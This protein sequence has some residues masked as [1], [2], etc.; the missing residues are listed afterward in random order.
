MTSRRSWGARRTRILSFCEPSKCPKRRWVR[1]ARLDVPS[2]LLR[3]V[4]PRPPGSRRPPRRPTRSTSRST[5]RSSIVVR[6]DVEVARNALPDERGQPRGLEDRSNLRS[7]RPRGCGDR[8]YCRFASPEG[9][10]EDQPT[11]GT[12]SSSTGGSTSGSSSTTGP[13]S[14]GGTGA[15]GST[16]S[17]P[18]PRPREARKSSSGAIAWR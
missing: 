16:S 13:S 6:A 18:L 3:G 17:S 10:A 7:A 11:G 9:P 14:A 8:T 2:K 12:G 4:G 1:F 5:P 15:D